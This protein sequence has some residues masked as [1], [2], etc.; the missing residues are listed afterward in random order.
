MDKL[1]SKSHL[2]HEKLTFTFLAS[3][4]YNI[5]PATT[6]QQ[7]A[8]EQT[9]PTQGSFV[10]VTESPVLLQGAIM[11]TTSTTVA[12]NYQEPPIA[13]EP[14]PV[15]M[16]GATT[17]EAEAA[18]MDETSTEVPLINGGVVLAPESTSTVEGQERLAQILST[19]PDEV[20]A[21]A[22]PLEP[23]GK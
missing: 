3:P 9:D 5:A 4:S 23:F 20:F 11:T 13:P 15:L 16:E 7:P 14:E 8:V 21:G 12:F 6:T 1:Y 22:R 18:A 2:V 10:E 17:A 19:P